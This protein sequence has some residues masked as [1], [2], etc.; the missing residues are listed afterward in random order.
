[1]R[2]KKEDEPRGWRGYRAG[3]TQHNEILRELAAEKGWLLADAA[4]FDTQDLDLRMSVFRDL[5]HLL[6]PGNQAKAAVVRNALLANWPSE[7][8]ER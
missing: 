7:L 2:P 8:G 6:P 4:Q 5:V 3:I 1:M